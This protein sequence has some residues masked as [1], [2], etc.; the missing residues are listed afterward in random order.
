MSREL[1]IHPQVLL[2][3][4]DLP[5]YFKFKVHPPCSASLSD[6][7]KWLAD[8]RLR[9]NSH[10]IALELLAPLS[11]DQRQEVVNLL[12]H[13]PIIKGVSIT[14]VVRAVEMSDGSP[15]VYQ[16]SFLSSPNVVSG[17][18]FQPVHSTHITFAL[19]FRGLWHLKS[20]DPRLL[21]V[22]LNYP[23][24]PQR[25]RSAV[26]DSPELYATKENLES[27]L[28]RR[29]HENYRGK[30]L[31]R[32]E[33]NMDTHSASTRQARLDSFRDSMRTLISEQ[34]QRAHPGKGPFVSGSHHDSSQ[35]CDM[36][37][38]RAEEQQQ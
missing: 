18:G 36:C 33:P 12:N 29:T 4:L 3:T 15:I 21:G 14:S 23:V 27:R 7:H 13:L 19:L 2:Y 17:A 5:D 38:P 30:A 24:L 26:P 16:R 32:F 8:F 31:Y 11:D 22:S 28:S 34:I 20:D 6:R 37:R 10:N 35:R 9:G 1:K 25:S